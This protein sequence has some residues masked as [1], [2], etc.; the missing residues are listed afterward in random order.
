MKPDI[1]RYVKKTLTATPP[2]CSEMIFEIT[3]DNYSYLLEL[4]PLVDVDIAELDYLV[5]VSAFLMDGSVDGEVSKYT[6]LIPRESYRFVRKINYDT[7]TLIKEFIKHYPDTE[8]SRLNP[9]ELCM[10]SISKTDTL[11]R[12]RYNDLQDLQDLLVAARYFTTIANEKEKLWAYKI[13]NK[14]KILIDA[15]KIEI[16]TDRDVYKED[17]WYHPRDK[18]YEPVT[19][20]ITIDERGVNK[21]EN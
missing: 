20:I 1:S 10:Y 15:Y 3:L 19:Q 21:C 16:T 11:Y 4:S 6:K 9:L 13:T 12:Y 2:D 18:K 14:M 7:T 17:G 8:G 5:M